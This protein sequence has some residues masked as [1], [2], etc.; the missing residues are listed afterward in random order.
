MLQIIKVF[1]VFLHSICLININFL[2]VGC[3]DKSI[4]IVDIKKGKV[5]KVLF[6]SD[7]VICIKSFIHPSFGIC[8]ISQEKSE[9]Y[10]INNNHISL[11]VDKKFF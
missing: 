5:I 7:D 8:L 6:G 3:G 4:K 10:G 2:A 11:W 9:F 1:G